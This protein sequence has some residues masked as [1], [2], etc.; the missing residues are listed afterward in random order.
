MNKRE[1]E[2]HPRNPL[3]LAKLALVKGKFLLA[4]SEE[5]LNAPSVHIDGK[6]LL[7]WK[8]CLSRDEYTKRFGITKGFLWIAQQNNSIVAVIHFALIPVYIVVPFTNCHE[9]DIRIILADTGGKLFGLLPDLV[10]KDD[11]M[12]RNAPIV[13]N[14]F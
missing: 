5:D 9:A 10:G 14:P 8:I 6:N 1:N 7:C 2:P 3:F 12:V 11:T 4:A 13:S